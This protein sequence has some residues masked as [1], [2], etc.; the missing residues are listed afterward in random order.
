MKPHQTKPSLGSR[1]NPGRRLFRTALVIGFASRV[2]RTQFLLLVLWVAVAQADPLGTQFWYSG[3]LNDNGQPANGNYDFIATLFN[4]ASGGNAQVAPQTVNNLPVVNGLVQFPLDFGGSVFDGT[5]LW[6]ELQVK[7]SNAQNFDPPLSPRMLLTA[8]PYALFAP[9][10]AS[11]NGVANNGVTGPSIQNASITA[12][13]IA[14]NQVVTSLNNLRDGVTLQGTP[15]LTITPNGNTLIL[16]APGNGIGWSLTGNSGTTA[17]QNFLG[18]TDNQPL[19]LWANSARVLRLEPASTFNP[20]TKQGS[21]SANV[22]GGYQ[23]NQVVNGAIGATIAGGGYFA[24]GQFGGYYPN[25]VGAAFGAIGGGAS[26]T[27][28]GLYGTIPGGSGNTANGYASFAAGVR[29]LAA[30]L[31]SFAAGQ[32]AQ[33]VH[34]GSFVWGDGT[35]T[36]ASTGPHRFEVFASGG[37]T[38][39]SSRGLGVNAASTI[40]SGGWD[41]FDLNLAPAQKAGLGRWGLFME[42]PGIVVGMPGTDVWG[43]LRTIAFGRYHPDGTYD[44]L[45]H[46]QNTDGQAWFL[47]QVS[48]CSLQIRGG[49][50]VAEPFPI[51]EAE[52]PEGAVVVIDD[53]RPGQLKISE[54]PYDT[55]V[56]GIVSGANGINPGLAL[57]QE[58]KLDSGRNVALSGRVYALA[59]ADNG[60]IQPGDLLTTSS[61]PGHA[62]KVADAARAQGAVL[63]KAMSPLRSGRGLVLVL[64]TLQ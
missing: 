25:Q 16:D 50:D 55:R 43:T 49:C 6:L 53:A 31:G 56:A 38:L 35:Q 60:S 20:I 2:F 14:A 29:S 39:S 40:I 44:E 22:V 32:Q 62:M 37:M 61:T 11:A 48:C 7:K 34:D 28:N 21:D 52:V 30:G 3:L 15:N 17:G 27:V 54:R 47:G 5:K 18:T 64:V 33:A 9:T 45:M 51:N 63:G 58:G 41:P 46:I 36:S 10:A 1:C 19:E 24:G 57:H 8:T 26:N 4:V 42:S 59:D 12:G 23:I 13:K